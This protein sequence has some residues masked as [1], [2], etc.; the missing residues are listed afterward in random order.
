MPTNGV[1][2]DRN[3]PKANA[4]VFSHCLPLGQQVLDT[5]AGNQ[6][7]INLFKFKTV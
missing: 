3:N 1:Q 6:G 7:P 2:P 4:V 5:L